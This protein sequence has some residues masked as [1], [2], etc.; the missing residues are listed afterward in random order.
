MWSYIKVAL[1]VAIKDAQ[2][3]YQT[4]LQRWLTSD[5]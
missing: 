3:R 2:D 1:K 4:M 5:C